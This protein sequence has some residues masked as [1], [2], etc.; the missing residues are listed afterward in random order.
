MLPCG[1]F[2]P[3]TREPLSAKD[4]YP[5]KVMMPVLSDD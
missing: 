3:V 4:L 1:S 5:N 2:E